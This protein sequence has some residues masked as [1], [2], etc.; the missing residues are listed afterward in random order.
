MDLDKLL[1]SG[2]RK[3]GRVLN[4]IPEE[5]IGSPM[6]YMMDILE[7]ETLPDLNI[8]L[9]V[10][11][12]KTFPIAALNRVADGDMMEG[13]PTMDSRY[14]AFRVPEELVDGGPLIGIKKIIQSYQSNQ[15]G[16]LHVHDHAFNHGVNQWGRMSSAVLYEK[17]LSTVLNYADAQL[18]GTLTPQIRA[19]YYPPNILWINKPYGDCDDLF[20]TVTFKIG[21]DKYLTS[22]SD[23]AFNTVKEL[24][25]LDLKAS[26][27]NEYGMFSEVD[28]TNGVSLNVRMDDWSNAESERQ[29]KFKEYQATA[30]FR[31]GSIFS[32]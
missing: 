31:N 26:L 25:I 16:S 4:V 22:V 17:S 30:H 23:M 15:N 1:K 3:C 20:I 5:D 2:M 28:T 10:L 29:E 32:G 27:Y 12:T 7:N 11:L 21:N 24:F 9:P 19:K 14:C 6:D 18:V 13:M 8:L